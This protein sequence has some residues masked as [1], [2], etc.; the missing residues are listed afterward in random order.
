MQTVLAKY[1][2]YELSEEE[3]V[4][5]VYEI[6]SESRAA[7]IFPEKV[8]AALKAGW[9]DTKPRN[10]AGTEARLLARL[11]QACLDGYYDRRA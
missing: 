1:A 3:V 4:N 2:E 10:D 6:A 5:G 11:V 9:A 8:V 7:G